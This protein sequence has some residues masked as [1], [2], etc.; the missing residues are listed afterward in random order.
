MIRILLIQIPGEGRM[1]LKFSFR[2][3]LQNTKN[4]WYLTHNQ[5]SIGI[6]LNIY[7]DKS[8][9]LSALFREFY[10]SRLVRFVTAQSPHHQDVDCYC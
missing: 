9:G 1:F 2:Y 10:Q 5:F 3:E 4:G 7:L 8:K 6:Y